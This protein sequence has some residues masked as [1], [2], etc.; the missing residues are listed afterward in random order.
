MANT[1]GPGVLRNAIWGMPARRPEPVLLVLVTGWPGPTFPT[2]ALA[3]PLTSRRFQPPRACRCSLSLPRR[4]RLSAAHSPSCQTLSMRP[5]RLPQGPARTSPA[6][7][8]LRVTVAWETSR[9]PPTPRPQ[10]RLT[11]GHSEH[12]IFREIFGPALISQKTIVLRL[13]QCDRR[14]CGPRRI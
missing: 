14:R 11:V 13:G 12:D 7:K 5:N 4:P 2:A 3:S 10:T 1:E 8:P 6:P 9:P